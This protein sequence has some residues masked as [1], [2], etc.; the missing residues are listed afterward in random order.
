MTTSFMRSMTLSGTSPALGCRGMLLKL[1]ADANDRASKHTIHG[2]VIDEQASTHTSH[3][4]VIELTIH[5]RNCAAGPSVS[6]SSM[7]GGAG[8]TCP[9][10]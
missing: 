2:Y 4:Y 8:V 9:I 1:W 10:F 6:T 3:G 5:S 7:D